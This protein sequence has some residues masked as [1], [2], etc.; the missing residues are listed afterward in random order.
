[1]PEAPTAGGSC[2]NIKIKTRNAA[3]NITGRQGH[4]GKEKRINIEEHVGG[5]KA[6]GSA[7]PGT[8]ERD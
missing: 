2:E 6:A 5:R 4:R 1:M 8:G 7:R 3:Q